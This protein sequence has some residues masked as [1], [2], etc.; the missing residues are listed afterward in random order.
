MNYQKGGKSD[1]KKGKGK[2]N[3]SMQCFNCKGFGH[4]AAECPSEKMIQGLEE[5]EGATHEEDLGRDDEEAAWL[6]METD[7]DDEEDFEEVVSKTQKKKRKM[8]SSKRMRR[9]S[10]WSSRRSKGN[11]FACQLEWTV[12]H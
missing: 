11:G 7:N 3:A 2:G 10:S 5:L 1:D 12:V 4:R 6:I 8:K 9:R